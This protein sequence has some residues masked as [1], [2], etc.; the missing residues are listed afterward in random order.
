MITRAINKFLSISMALVLVLVAGGCKKKDA[1]PPPPQKTA[2]PKA[3]P[4][5]KALSSSA[6]KQA[7][8]SPQL[9]FRT[10]K[11]PF[12]PFI[13]ASP[14]TPQ[15]VGKRR[16]VGLLPIQNYD[17]NQFKVIGIVAGLK[18]NRAMIVDPAGKGYVV[19]QGMLI[20]KNDGHVTRIM[21]G[22]IE[23]QEQFRDDS[24]KLLRRTVKLTLP[25]KE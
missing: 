17:L 15:G 19:K 11:D 14:K 24:G 16:G 20:G 8:G 10:K 1:V 3:A 18:E 7:A 12:K 4:V 21:P 25:R 22:W 9:D 5:Q 6:A 13:V 2:A 23:V